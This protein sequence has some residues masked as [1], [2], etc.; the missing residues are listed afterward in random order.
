MKT[1]NNTNLSEL[2]LI[3]GA[4]ENNPRIQEMLYKKFSPKMYRI[5]YQ[6]SKNPI[7]TEDLLQNGF[8]KVFSNLDKYKATGSFEGWMSRIFINVS[9]SHFNKARQHYSLSPFE[10]IISDRN[11]CT[12]NKYAAEEILKIVEQLSPGYR[13]I[14]KLYAIEGYSHKEIGEILGISEGTSKS[15][16]AR[17][18]NRLRQLIKQN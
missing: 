8:M 3:Q 17:A 12:I 6:Y 13:T 15:Q 14:F 4:L 10:E 9:I 11:N 2:D 1:H 16:F 5:C 18:K 7:D